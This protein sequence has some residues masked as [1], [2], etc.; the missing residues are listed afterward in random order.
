VGRVRS[1]SFFRAIEERSEKRLAR[2]NGSVCQAPAIRLI[3]GK[4]PLERVPEPSALGST[5]YVLTDSLAA[6]P[7]CAI[8]FIYRVV[9]LFIS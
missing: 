8:T 2:G 6:D 1:W 3:S 9:R 5:D 4:A 7:F